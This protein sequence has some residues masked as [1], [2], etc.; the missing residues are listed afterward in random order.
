[1]NHTLKEDGKNAGEI[2]IKKKGPTVCLPAGPF[3]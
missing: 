3:S 1:M 2:Q